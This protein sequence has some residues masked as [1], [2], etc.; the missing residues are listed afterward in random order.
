MLKEWSFLGRRAVSLELTS[1]AI[2]LCVIKAGE[3]L[4]LCLL[5]VCLF[6]G[7]WKRLQI[8]ITRSVHTA[9]VFAVLAHLHLM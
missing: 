7:S 8:V 6:W 4:S 1:H 2:L 5:G 9:A 3:L